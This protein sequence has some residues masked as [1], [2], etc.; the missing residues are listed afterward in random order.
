MNIRLSCFHWLETI[1]F[2]TTGVV[3]SSSNSPVRRAS[4][5]N[6]L[7]AQPNKQLCTTFTAKF[8]GMLATFIKAAQERTKPTPMT[9]KKTPK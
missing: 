3:S 9:N 1:V 2:A 7:A 4:T 6:R 8:T 5:K